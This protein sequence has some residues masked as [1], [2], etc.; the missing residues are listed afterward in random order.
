MLS[1]DIRKKIA[2]CDYTMNSGRYQTRDGKIYSRVT[3]ILSMIRFDDGILDKWRKKMTINDFCKRIDMQGVYKGNK[4]FNEFSKSLSAADD[5]TFASAAFGTK[6]HNWIESYM[7]TGVFQILSTDEY[8][9]VG[10][11]SESVKKFLIENNI[12][13]SSVEIVKPELF[14]YSQKYGYAGSADFVCGRGDSY[15]LFDWKTSN[16]YRVNYAL[17]LSAYAHAIEELY[18]IHIKKATCV[19]FNKEIVGYEKHT[20]SDEELKYYFEL[21]KTCLVLHNFIKGYPVPAM[22]IGFKE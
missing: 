19:V 4:V 13:P 18:G 1:D 22:E 21:F 10:I 15:Y 5:Y 7:N 8:A 11:C 20:L 12:S 3:S 2:S 6:V 9:S 17:Q 16:R 14:V